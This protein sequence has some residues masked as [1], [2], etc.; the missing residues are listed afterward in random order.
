M[1][2]PFAEIS[3]S[4]LAAANVLVNH[5]DRCGSS[6]VRCADMIPP[7][8]DRGYLPPGLHTAT[9]DELE[10]RFGNESELRRVQMESLRWLVDLAQRA[11]S[12]RLIV[13]GSFVTDI[14]EPNDIDCALLVESDFLSDPSVERE[15]KEG[16]P[17]IDLHV[18]GN[19]EFMLFV[20]TIFG[21]DRYM[22]PKGVVEILL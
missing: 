7:F 2:E 9:L 5:A 1:V 17:F 10:A 11:G 13:N 18:F 22:I 3:F 8:D 15:L 4:A 12:R 6:G 16:L 14:L 21:T 20:D 19:E